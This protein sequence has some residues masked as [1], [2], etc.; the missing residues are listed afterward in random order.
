MSLTQPFCT[1]VSDG[2][3]ITLPPEFWGELVA[4][5]VRRK[6]P[7]QPVD[8]EEFWR[9]QSLDEID[10]GQGGP[11]ICTSPDEYFGFLSEFWGSKEDVETFLRKRKE[12]P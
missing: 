2:G 1:I 7:T 4:V 10:A 6:S 8:R 11:K 9:K 12:E 3:T 5:T